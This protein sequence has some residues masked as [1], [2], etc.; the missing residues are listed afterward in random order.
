MSQPTTPDWQVQWLLE[1]PTTH[2]ETLEHV[3]RHLLTQLAQQ[4]VQQQ[5]GVLQ[6]EC[7]LVCPQRSPLILSVGLFQPATDSQHW[8][9]LL[10]L[11]LD[12]L[13]LPDVVEEIRVVAIATGPLETRQVEL[14]VCPTPGDPK[15]LAAFIERA[16]SRL[17]RQRVVRPQLQAEAQVE[18]AYRYVPLAGDELSG[19][20][21]R[22]TESG[23]G[24]PAACAPFG[25]LLRP[26]WLLDPPQ[27]IDVM[28]LALDRP[29]AVFHYQGRPY[30][31]VRSFG[32][33]RIETGWWRGPSSR[34]DYYRVETEAGQ[35]FWLF[36]R[37]QDQ[38]WF[39]HGIF[40]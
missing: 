7:R 21:G 10:Q 2:R 11:Q 6:L 4:L 29:P 3:L 12:R 31:V 25:P 39:V 15:K 30:R 33:E 9:S 8:M 20:S 27:P 38:Q 18:L 26:L 34:R 13:T 19:G 32:P 24:S 35:R 17:G 5:Q 40:E 36:H 28:G 1:S 37:L 22:R 23:P 16:S 14:F